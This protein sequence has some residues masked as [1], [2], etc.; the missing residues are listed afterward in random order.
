M[1]L[2]FALKFIGLHLDSRR[3]HVMMQQEKDRRVVA[4]DADVASYGAALSQGAYID[5]RTCLKPAKW[6]AT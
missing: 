3:K 4:C 1:R 6:K 2:S 5:H